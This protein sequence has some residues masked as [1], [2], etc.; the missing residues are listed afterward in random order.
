MDREQIETQIHEVR[1]TQTKAIPLSNKQFCPDGLFAKLALTEAERWELIKT[2]LFQKARRRL[3]ELQRAEMAAFRG[4]AG[5]AG[6]ELSD[7]LISFRSEEIT[8]R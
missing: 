5:Q 6:S 2:P 7:G 8:V 4:A 1:A 3:S